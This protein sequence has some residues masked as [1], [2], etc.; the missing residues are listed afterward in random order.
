MG[1][2]SKLLWE[3][4]DRVKL[5][6]RLSATGTLGRRLVP[7]NLSGLGQAVSQAMDHVH[8]G[9]NAI[10][11]RMNSRTSF[12]NDPVCSSHEENGK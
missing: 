9:P 6:R 7:V 3:D 1:Q 2:G 4:A 10:T 8:R 12:P 5:G 11:A